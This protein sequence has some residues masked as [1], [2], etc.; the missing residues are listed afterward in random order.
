MAKLQGAKDGKPFTKNDGRINRQGR[1]P[2]LPDLDI[3]LAEVLEE[4]VN[5]KEALKAVLIALRKKALAGDVRAAE[6]LLDRAY[7]KLKTI[8]DL[9]VDFKQ[10]S[11]HDLD[12]IAFRLINTPKK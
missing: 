9:T 7:G 8:Q 4:K 3:L 12:E 5:G 11:E 10:M 1:P 6:L 2:K